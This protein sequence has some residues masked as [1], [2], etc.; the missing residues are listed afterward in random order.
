MIKITITHADVGGREKL[1]ALRAVLAPT[2]L[3]QVAGRAGVN[4]VRDHL[5]ALNSARP[6]KL[7]GTRQNYYARAADSTHFTAD[8]RRA[9]V[10]V[11][12]VG[13]RLRRFGGVVRPVKSKALTIPL[14]A[15]AYGRL[16]REF[17]DTF[18]WRNKKTGKA[19]VAD[20]N[21]AGVLR[22]LYLL[23]T[24]ANIPEDPSLMP[25]TS[26]V[27]AAAAGSLKSYLARQAARIAAAQQPERPS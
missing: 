10:T 17:P 26:D 9:R 15:I 12:H 20:K 25:Q 8:E 2:E 21:A 13:F 5:Y 3:N 22:L 7:G 19:F 16:A 11:S 4:L 24:E 6:N 27:K 14:V 23:V 18:I 1:A